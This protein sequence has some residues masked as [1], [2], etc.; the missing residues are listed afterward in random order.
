[1]LCCWELD[2]EFPIRL[3]GI[4]FGVTSNQTVLAYLS[5]TKYFLGAISSLWST[6][7]RETKEVNSVQSAMEQAEFSPTV[8]VS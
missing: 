5:W 6:G 2:M 3:L 8:N 4:A 7:L 1:M